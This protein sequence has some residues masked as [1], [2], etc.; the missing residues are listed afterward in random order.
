MQRSI[1]LALI[2]A[3]LA[4]PAALGQQAAPV[5]PVKSQVESVAAEIEVLVLD[6]KG[7][8]AEGLARSDFKLFVNGKESPI[9]YLEPPLGPARPPASTSASGPVGAD[10]T[11]ASSGPS[12]SPRLS[13]STVFVFNPLHLDAR[14]R[15]NGLNAMRRY[16]DRMPA[17][18]SGTVFVIDNGLR[19]L[20]AFTS[21]R[22]ELGKAID[23]AGK[24]LPMS[25]NFDVGGEEWLARSRQELRSMATLFNSIA[26]RPEPKTVLVLA[27]AL[28]ATGTI[29]PIGGSAGSAAA[30]QTSFD[31]GRAKDIPG[32]RAGYFPRD[33]TMT[34]A[35]AL[36]S[37]STLSTRGMWSLLPEI[38]D[39]GSEALLAR[40]TVIALDP[41]E[42]R[43]ENATAEINSLRKGDKEV[44]TTS[45]SLRPGDNSAE[46][47][48]SDTW[49]FRNDSFALIARDTG[50]SRL[51]Y[52]NDPA[53][54]V[55]AE[56]DLL[57]RRYRLGFTPPDPTSARRAVRIEISRPGFLVRTA[58]GQ[59][60]ITPETAA[61]ARFAALLLS[62]D[63]PTGDFVIVL[64]TKGPVSKRT[65]D[66]FPF[67]VVIPIAGVY[68][69]DTPG[70][71]RAKLEI[72]VS[73]V[74]DEGRASDP[75]VIPF[76]ATL[77]KEAAVDG[78]FFRKD[79]NFNIDRRWKG[80]LFVG[81]RDTAT[82]RIGAVALPIGS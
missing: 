11:P 79:A 78:A 28:S 65:D 64:E 61:R 25:Y 19:R 8:A 13:H 33:A 49:E 70:G 35:E 26:S 39:V 45:S 77:T 58:S 23:R 62:A 51:G 69:E 5:R 1:S 81:V 80:R 50:G 37:G 71:K 16:V 15:Q 24:G 52:S 48:A 54:L 3:S 66:A 74:D 14:S 59:R 76:S 42:L 68:A 67:D 30:S 82:S 4:G 29:K 47:D 20:V 43:S 9:D 18:E 10:A 41:T 53:G 46:S 60:S 40:A 63:A 38:R 55:L 72:L 57:S 31:V 6:S 34:E 73:T 36:G 12:T 32:G 44:F 75:V 21:D 22:K 7:K 2:A 56:S 27:G 17:G